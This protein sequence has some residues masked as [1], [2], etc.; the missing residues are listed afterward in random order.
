MVYYKV[1]MGIMGSLKVN[2]KAKFD[3]ENHIGFG[4]YNLKLHQFYYYYYDFTYHFYYVCFIAFLRP[5]KCFFS[6]PGN[7]ESEID[8]R[9][10]NDR[11]SIKKIT[12][13]RKKN[14]F[15]S[16]WYISSKMEKCLIVDFGLEMTF[17]QNRSVRIC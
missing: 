9:P 4:L 8:P 6:K 2:V 17:C 16:K 1:N 11:R 7:T 5:Q 12:H 15:W 3:N 14:D 10:L 13:F